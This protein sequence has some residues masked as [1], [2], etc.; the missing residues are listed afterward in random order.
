MFLLLSAPNAELGCGN[1]AAPGLFDLEFRACFQRVKAGEELALI[2]S[3][4]E[5]GA[6]GHVTADA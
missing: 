6:D 4:I 1:P 3:A 2:G 5:E